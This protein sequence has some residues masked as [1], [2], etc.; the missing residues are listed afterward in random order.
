MPIP[1]LTRPRPAQ[2]RRTP[3]FSRTP[4][5]CTRRPRHPGHGPNDGPLSRFSEFVP[6]EGDKSLQN[7]L[8]RE[9]LWQ[10]TRTTTSDNMESTIRS[11]LDLVSEMLADM[12]SKGERDLRDRNEDIVRREALP[13]I[14]KWNQTVIER[15]RISKTTKE[16]IDREI[17]V[18][19]AI[20]K[21]KEKLRRNRR[22]QQL[23]RSHGPGPAISP[24]SAIRCAVKGLTALPLK[25]FNINS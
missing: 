10:A 9:V 6:A 12:Y 4:A 8:V 14:S 2:S 17:A 7:D 20:L 3:H 18:V 19:N 24:Q 13:N 15:H 22:Q 16:E 5:M 1:L 23:T 21:R 25:W 11:H